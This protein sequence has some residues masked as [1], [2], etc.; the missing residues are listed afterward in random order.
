M[1]QGPLRFQYAEENR[2]TSVTSLSGVAAYLDMAQAAGLSESVRTHVSVKEGGQGWTDSQIVTAVVLLNLV[3]GES[4]DDLVDIV[5]IL[6]TVAAAAGIELPTDQTFD[7]VS[8]WEQLQGN[9]GTPREWIHTYYWPQPYKRTHDRPVYH[10]EISYARDKVYKLYSTGELFNT[11]EDRLELYPLP[12]DD[13]A[14]AEARSSLQAV[15][16]SKS[17]RGW[18]LFLLDRGFGSMPDGGAQRPRLRPVLRAASVDRDELTLSY[19][20]LVRRSPLPPTASFTVLVDGDEVPV[21]EVRIAEGDASV[22]TSGITDVTLALESEVAA[23]QDVTVS[24]VPGSNPIA[25]MSRTGSAGAAPLSGRVVVNNTNALPTGQPGI[26]GSG[27]SGNSLLALTGDIMDAN[28]LD[29]VS[30]SYQWLLSDNGADTEIE[31]ANRISYRLRSIEEG[32]AI[33]VRVTF[34]DDA[35]HDA[36][37]TSAPVALYRPMSLTARESGGAVVLTWDPPE[38]FPLLFNYN[39]FRQRPEGGETKPL[40]YADT[41]RS[42]EATYTDSDVAPGAFYIYRVQAMHYW[43]WPSLLSGSAEI[44]TPAGNTAATGAPTATGTARVGETLTADTSGITDPDGLDNATFSYQWLADDVDISG[45]TG[46]SYTLTDFEEGKAVKVTVSFTDD[47]GNGESLTSAATASVAGRNR[48]RHARG[49]HPG[50]HV[51]PV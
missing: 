45:A 43:G 27:F 47:A 41:G 9:M 40:F 32:S 2:A 14:S 12:A 28:G 1:P 26:R 49:L 21:S 36:T 38:G 24:Y 15:L 46:A 8:F 3:G 6:P 51:H 4:V 5:D 16:D 7:G 13:G 31:G 34:T 33:K 37:L 11:V 20:G 42:R 10:P 39:I 29:N 48:G 25:H 18:G 23:G 30:Y 19:V 50:G 35:G 44:R 22:V 17:G